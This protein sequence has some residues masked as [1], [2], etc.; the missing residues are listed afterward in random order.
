[1]TGTL[2][3]INFKAVVPLLEKS[4]DKALKISLKRFIK[5]LNEIK[6]LA[7]AKSNFVLYNSPVEE[8]KPF[9]TDKVSLH[10]VEY[11]PIQ[12]LVRQFA[13]VKYREQ[14]TFNFND[15][16]PSFKTQLE[17][18]YKDNITDSGVGEEVEEFIRSKMF[19]KLDISKRTQILP[20]EI[21]E[22]IKDI[23]LYL[24]RLKLAKIEQ[25]IQQ[26]VKLKYNLACVKEVIDNCKDTINST[27]FPN[28]SK[29]FLTMDN[30]YYKLSKE[31]EVLE[32]KI[33]LK[34]QLVDK[35]KLFNMI[36]N[37]SSQTSNDS[38]NI[39]EFK[40]LSSLKAK[41]DT[42]LRITENLYDDEEDAEI[43]IME[44]DGADDS[45]EEIVID[46]DK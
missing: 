9:I 21:Q 14:T 42:N 5:V 4:R 24:K 35:Q 46:D 8:L 32:Q 36:E 19:E 33:K 23:D 1:M 3:A 12:R 40:P 6:Y 11:N 15:Y 20:E 29:I 25:G 34:I 13:E 43:D 30:I 10:T 2:N 26:L 41:K 45:D 28:K 39:S 27:T 22:N 16:L 31:C 44:S 18:F 7:Y 38:P 37:L 17:D